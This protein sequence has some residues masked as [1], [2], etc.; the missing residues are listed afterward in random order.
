MARDLLGLGIARWDMECP[1]MLLRAK[2][3]IVLNATQRAVGRGTPPLRRYRFTIAG[4]IGYWV[5]HCLE[6]RAPTVE[7][8]LPPGDGTACAARFDVSPR[9]WRLYGFGLHTRL[10]AVNA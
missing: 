9:Q 6:D 7:P 8:L 5:C 10:E 2:R 3:P 1:G 4:E